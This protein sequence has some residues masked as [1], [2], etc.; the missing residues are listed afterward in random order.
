MSIISK[1][2]QDLFVI[3]KKELQKNKNKENISTIINYFTSMLLD[4]ISPYFY[5][6]LIVLIIMFI[7][8]FVQFYYYMKIFIVT[9]NQNIQSLDLFTI[10][11]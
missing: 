3:I 5:T 4:K 6:I 10:N 2:T 11:N 7:M 1:A 8:N 9:N